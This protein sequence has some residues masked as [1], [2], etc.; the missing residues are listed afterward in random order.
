MNYARKELA[1]P[2]G[3]EGIVRRRTTKRSGAAS[4]YNRSF[5]GLG[6]VTRGSPVSE[7]LYSL[8]GWFNIFDMYFKN[9][10]IF[11]PFISRPKCVPRTFL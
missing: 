11:I 1:W 9:V 4:A 7:L 5:G 2:M 10:Y 8:S 6:P 3:V